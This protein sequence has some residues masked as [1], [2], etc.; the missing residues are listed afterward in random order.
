MG[1]HGYG[2]IA[3]ISPRRKS[4]E[5]HGDRILV[6]TSAAGTHLLFP[7]VQPLVT[8]ICPEILPP[9]PS[10]PCLWHASSSNLLKLQQPLPHVTHH[11]LFAAV[12]QQYMTA[13]HTLQHL[14]ENMLC[15]RTLIPA[16]P[17]ACRTSYEIKSRFQ[18]FPGSKS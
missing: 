1:L 10:P 13:H 2:S 16:A 6:H 4:G 17:T 11:S 3:D 8:P 14:E 5:G 18:V 15:A 9:L 7:P 12:V